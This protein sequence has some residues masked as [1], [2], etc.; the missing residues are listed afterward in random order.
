[1]HSGRRVSSAPCY[2]MHISGIQN[3][4]L[5]LQAPETQHKLCQLKMQTDSATAWLISHLK[6]LQQTHFPELFFKYKTTWEAF[7]VLALNDDPVD[8][9][10]YAVDWWVY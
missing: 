8:W 10:H 5:P 7:R 2:L 1:M 9:Y 3:D 4:V 6:C